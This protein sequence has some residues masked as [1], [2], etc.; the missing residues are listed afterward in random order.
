MLGRRECCLLLGVLAGCASAGPTDA[1]DWRERVLSAVA[2]EDRRAP[3]LVQQANLFPGQATANPTLNTARFEFFSV[4]MG[5]LVE[6]PQALVFV[7]WNGDAG[8]YEVARLVV[9]ATTI[10]GIA[11]T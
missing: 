10:P 8:R 7:A 4:R 2:P 9:S 5:A 3:R 6:T 11:D 1:P